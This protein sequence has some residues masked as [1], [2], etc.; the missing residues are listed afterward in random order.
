MVNAT[1]GQIDELVKAGWLAFGVSQTDLAEI[2]AVAFNRVEDHRNASARSHS[3]R[4]ARIAEA[5]ELPPDWVHGE[6]GESRRNALSAQALASLQSLLDLRLL[7]AFRELRD[8]RSRRMLVHLVEAIV[9]AQASRLD[10]R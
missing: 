1:Q 9:K 10:E 6:A 7:H 3:L 5:V 8:Q 2:L 4:T